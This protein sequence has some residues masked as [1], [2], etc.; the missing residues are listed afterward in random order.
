MDSFDALR[1]RFSPVV[2]SAPFRYSVGV[3]RG[4]RRVII[5]WFKDESDAIDYLDRCRIGRPRAKFDYLKS[6]F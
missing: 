3:Y 6:Y 1:P 4:G 5:A 2:N